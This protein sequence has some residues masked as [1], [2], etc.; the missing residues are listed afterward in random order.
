M[1]NVDLQVHISAVH[2]GS[3]KFK[4][5]VCQKD[6][7][8]Q[9]YL[10]NHKALVHESLKNPN[11]VSHGGK[12]NSISNGNV[13]KELQKINSKTVMPPQ[14]NKCLYCNKVYQRESDLKRH[15]TIFHF[16]LDP[17]LMLQLNGSR[18]GIV[19]K[20]YEYVYLKTTTRAKKLRKS[21]TMAKMKRGAR[22]P[23]QMCYLK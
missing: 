18:K 6:F 21:H 3:K 1:K 5:D 7:A 12:T 11:S 8:S 10:K 19:G 9:L 22:K 23:F 15:V 17:E 14:E 2:G 20:F 13:L 16:D 4:C